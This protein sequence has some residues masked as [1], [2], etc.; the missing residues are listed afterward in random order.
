[1]KYKVFADGVEL[2]TN[3]AR[4][5]KMPFNMVW[6]GYQRDMEQT[7]L[8]WFV[9]F[10]MEKNIT[11]EI[12]VLGA[13]VKTAV[14]RPIEYGIDY[15]IDG[16]KITVKLDEPKKFVLEVNGIHETLNVFA[17][18][19]DTFVPD[20]NTI[21]F[22]AGEHH[23]GMIYPRSGQ[24]VYIADG[25]VVYGGIYA[26]KQDNVTVRGRGI[27]DSSE[28]L[29][30]DQLSEDD[31]FYKELSAV[32]LTDRDIRLITGFTAYECNNFTVDGIVLRDA[33][34][35]SMIIRNGC[36]NVKIN[37]V[38]LIGQWR[39]NADGFD[40]CAS[41]NIK[42]TDC[43]VRS[44][45]DSV[46]IRAVDLDGE[47]TPCDNILVENNVLWCDWGKN[48]EI[49]CGDKN[50][51]VKNVTFRNNYLVHVTDYAIS[52]DTWF[53]A[54]S[55]TVDG[56]LYENIY[57]DTRSD[58]LFPVIQES[59]EH[60]YSYLDKAPFDNRKGTWIGV[61]RLGK[62]LGNQACDFSADCSGYDIRYKN[63]TLRNVTCNGEYKLPVK[64][65]SQYLT[66]LSNVTLEN[67]NMGN[68]LLNK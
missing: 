15:S 31:E 67:C 18:E 60:K 53:G 47:T 44:F 46:V 54:P 30:G 45:D 22:G 62:N 17:N 27:L 38:K 36:N 56:V 7:E 5:S 16:N 68:Y 19:K 33:P 34:F 66:E 65:S 52:I 55:L 12:E 35:W 64:I 39:Y 37:N 10:D 57:I 25:A 26:Y 59:P 1:M 28:I 8:A 11:L 42:L 61:G 41:M 13:D 14:I 43:F 58:I 40:L 24:T 21:Y 29:R 48:L 20:E 3:Y 32:G 49:W 51:V 6:K 9:S 4:V 2:V 63:I 23:T 50:A